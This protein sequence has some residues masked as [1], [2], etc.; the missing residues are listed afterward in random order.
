MDRQQI[1]NKHVCAHIVTADGDVV[2][3]FL[4]FSEPNEH[5]IMGY[6]QSITV[7]LAME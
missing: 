4:G 2:Q 3:R 6:L 1:D 7:Y 5:G